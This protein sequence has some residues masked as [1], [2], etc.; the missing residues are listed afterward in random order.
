MNENWCILLI[1]ILKN[2]SVEQSFYL[3]NNTKAKTNKTITSE[4]IEDMITLSQQGISYRDIGDMYGI[5][6][7]SVCKRIK[8]LRTGMWDK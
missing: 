6:R 4:D 1:A 7:Y 8:Y 3:F 5:S 2:T